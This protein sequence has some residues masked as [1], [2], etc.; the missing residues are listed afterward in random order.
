MTN[1]RSDPQTGVSEHEA[2][3]M[4]HRMERQL[5]EHAADVFS[6]GARAEAPQLRVTVQDDGLG[7]EASDLPAVIDGGIRLD[8]SVA[9]SGLGLAGRISCRSTPALSNA[10]RSREW[11]ECTAGTSVNASELVNTRTRTPAV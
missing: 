9:G 4:G 1:P 3:P 7:I 11:A 6:A 5:L 2:G 8:E 10:G